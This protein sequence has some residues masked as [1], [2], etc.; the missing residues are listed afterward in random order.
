[1]RLIPPIPIPISNSYSWL[2]QQVQR[3]IGAAP[4]K[5]EHKPPHASM[6]PKS[7]KAPDPYRVHKPSA[8]T[9]PKPKATNKQTPASA[10]QPG[11]FQR[12]QGLPTQN[13]PLI[14]PSLSVPKWQEGSSGVTPSPGSQPDN[15]NASQT[16]R[17]LPTTGTYSTTNSSGSSNAY[18]HQ[19]PALPTSARA[20][21]STYPAIAVRPITNQQPPTA[22]SY[23][24]FFSQSPAIRTPISPLTSNV[25]ADLPWLEYKP[26]CDKSITAAAEPIET[27]SYN[28]VYRLAKKTADNLAQMLKEEK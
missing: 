9:K 10:Q 20:T 6:K 3:Q 14:N 7:A 17:T 22:T 27:K 4:I 11:G 18:P 24:S 23:E 13:V 12:F 19:F 25:P 1:M 21:P 15:S 16:T 5:S 26:G 8:N 28:E 2:D